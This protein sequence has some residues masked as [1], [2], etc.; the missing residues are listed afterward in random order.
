MNLYVRIFCC[1]H[2]IVSGTVRSQS[3]DCDCDN[4]LWTYA[5]LH[6]HTHSVGIKDTHQNL[7]K[8]FLDTDD[9]ELLLR[10]SGGLYFEETVMRRLLDG[11]V[12]THVHTHNKTMIKISIK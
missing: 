9:G 11:Q 2:C 6:T 4:I 7:R 1:I 5:H 8:S 10:R 3:V 12:C